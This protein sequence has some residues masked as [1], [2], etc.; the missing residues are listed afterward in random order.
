MVTRASPGQT[1]QQKGMRF[2]VEKPK[3]AQMPS[4]LATWEAV[5]YPFGLTDQPETWN[6]AGSNG[7]L[8][9][10]ASPGQPAQPKGMR[11]TVENPQQ[12][13]RPSLLATW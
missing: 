7:P 1:A 3:Q 4:L 12:T 8:V 11:F 2:T 9:T 13:Q 6:V 5:F 10:R